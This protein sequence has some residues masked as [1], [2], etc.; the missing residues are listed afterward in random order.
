MKP[1]PSKNMTLA[2]LDAYLAARKAQ[3][4]RE[5]SLSP[6]SPE[7][8]KKLV[9]AGFDPN[10]NFNQQTWEA[11]SMGEPRTPVAPGLGRLIGLVLIFSVCCIYPAAFIPVGFLFVLIYLEKKREQIRNVFNKLLARL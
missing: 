10:F 3:A 5:A 11:M 1:L 8:K 9:D 6:I 4:E 7:L 2:E